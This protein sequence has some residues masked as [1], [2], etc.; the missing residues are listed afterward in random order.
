MPKKFPLFFFE[1]SEISG[2]IK[3]F[4]IFKFSIF[5][6]SL[7]FPENFQKISKN[8]FLRNIFDMK[9]KRY[10]TVIRIR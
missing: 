8:M 3:I 5:E 9:K 10:D 2:K 7:D 4:E 6:I 1:N